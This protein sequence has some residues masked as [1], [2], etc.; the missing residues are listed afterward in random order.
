MNPRDHICLALDVFE[1]DEAKKLVEA[2]SEYIGYFKVGMSF[3]D[4]VKSISDMIHANGGKVF[5]DMKFHD[6]PNT[7]SNAAKT[8]T[9]LGVDI[10]NIHAIGGTEMMRRT[11]DSTKE[12]ADNIGGEPPDIYA[13]TVLTSIDKITLDAELKVRMGLNNYVVYLAGLAKEAGLKGVVCSGHEVKAIKKACGK[14]FKLIVPGIRPKW[15]SETDDQK[16]VFTP[17]RAIKDG[18]DILVV[19]RPIIM[20]E[21][22]QEAAKR[23]F[24]E[25][26]TTF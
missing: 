13:V 21:S 18:A 4:K 2:T 12:E 20:A 7:V 16:R 23:L 26:D 15:M 9:R 19:G 1:F 6:I 17:E 8:A 11:L 24:H 14:D 25:I 22:H 10:F 3:F 5:L